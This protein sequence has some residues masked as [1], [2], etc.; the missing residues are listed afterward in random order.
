MVPKGLE[1]AMIILVMVDGIS[2]NSQTMLYILAAVPHCM[3]YIL[4]A[5]E[6]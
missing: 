2:R 3:G 4:A 6:G 5:P 1:I